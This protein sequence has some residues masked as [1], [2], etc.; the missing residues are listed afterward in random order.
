AAVPAHA[1]PVRVR[2]RQPAPGRVPRARPAWLLD[3]V[4]RRDRQA[5][6]H[7]RRIRRLAAA[8]AAGGHLHPWLDAPARAQLGTPAPAGVRDRRA[9][10]AALLVDRQVRLPRAAALRL[11]PGAAAGLAVVEAAG[12]A[13]GARGL[14]LSRTAAAPQA[15]GRCPPR[16]A[17]AT[18]GAR[19]GR[20]ARLPGPATQP[21]RMH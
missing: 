8:G 5:P 10:G 4:V 15:A 1:G 20:R 18:A 12:E 9:G 3:A 14:S 21:A 11:D 2:L 19:H 6:L 17:A 7:H 16:R 13:T